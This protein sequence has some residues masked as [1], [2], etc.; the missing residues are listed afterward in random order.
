MESCVI[1]EHGISAVDYK[2]D[3]IQIEHEDIR[4]PEYSLEIDDEPPSRD[5]LGDFQEWNGETLQ[6]PSDYFGHG[7]QQL[8]SP[9]K[10][11]QVASSIVRTVPVPFEEFKSTV[12][13]QEDVNLNF[14]NLLLETF[15]NHHQMVALAHYET[16]E[17]IQFDS[18]QNM[19]MEI[20]Q[21]LAN[22]GFQTGHVCIVVFDNDH[23]R[24]VV[25]NVKFIQRC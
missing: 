16:H 22:V 24:Y 7:M 14:T 11:F 10:V 18:L 9:E 8:S 25:E 13:D 19:V 2:Q 15:Q 23:T 21:G 17:R 6:S 5:I 1:P 12:F 3:Y 20:C 4:A